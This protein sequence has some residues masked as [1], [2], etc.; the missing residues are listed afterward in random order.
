MTRLTAGI[1]HKRSIFTKHIL[2][3]VKFI[4]SLFFILFC[5]ALNAQ[6]L[7]GLSVN[8]K[9]ITVQ[10][11]K[12]TVNER[13]SDEPIAYY[14]S[15]M[16][17]RM[18][19]LNG[20]KSVKGKVL[21]AVSIKIKDKTGKIILENP[22]VFKEENKTGGLPEDKITASL[23][24]MVRVASPMK[25]KEEYTAVFFVDDKNGPA[26]ISG[27]FK[28]TSRLLPISTYTEK[29]IKSDGPVFI[30]MPGNQVVTSQTLKNPEKLYCVFNNLSG[31]TN[32]KGKVFPD[33]RV[34][35]KD[36][37]GRV[38]L[39]FPDLFKAD[40]E[41]GGLNEADAKE[42][43]ALNFNFTEE[44]AKGEQYT[45]IFYVGDKKSKNSLSAAITV[46]WT[47]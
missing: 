47:K 11:Y 9:S 25:L 41:K 36:S 23:D 3:M 7:K 35:I 40:N 45:C 5:H 21:L 4:A 20:L 13:K 37:Q 44:P 16:T 29:G 6:Q 14:G 38:V 1:K 33:A 39:D 10:E 12:Y 28:F 32:V 46:I 34:T 31:F 2:V 8:T 24:L 30:T 17:L 42:Q 43:L 15:I 27:S 19:K 26:E 22:D 18:I